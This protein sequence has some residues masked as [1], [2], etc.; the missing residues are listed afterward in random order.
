MGT[1][2]GY[3]A[4]RYTGAVLSRLGRSLPA[5][6]SRILLVLGLTGGLLAMHAVTGFRSSDAPGRVAMASVLESVMPMHGAEHRQASA[7][8][9]GS[10][11]GSMSV[12]AMIGCAAIS[13]ATSLPLL[14]DPLVGVAHQ[15]L[16]RVLR[17]TAQAFGPPGGVV[18]GAF[19]V[20]RI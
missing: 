7:A 3:A 14:V 12:T 2:E 10:A 18:S 5:T 19:V 4:A 20:L 11:P 1:P 17:G 13:G 8:D 15:V 9:D 6:I 16:P